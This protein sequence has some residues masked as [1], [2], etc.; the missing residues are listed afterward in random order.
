MSSSIWIGLAALGAGFVAAY[1]TLR[2]SM[3]RTRLQ[4]QAEA[5]SVLDLARRKAE[6]E[7]LEAR[8]KVE[9][10][11]EGLRS[12]FERAE[13]RSELEIENKLKEIRS[14]EESIG[15]LDHQLEL[16]Q[17]QIEKEL[18]ELK[19]NRDSLSQMSANMQRTM[20]NLASM[21]VSEI[22]ESLREQVRLD[23][24]DE[25]KKLRKEVLERSEAEIHREARR[26]L[27]AAMQRIASKPNN[28][29]TAAI[30]QLPNDEMK[31]RIIG[32]EGRNIKCFETA[33]GTTLLIDESP[34]MVMV[35]SFDPVRREIA[36]TALERLVKDGRIH[37]ATIEEF[38]GEARNDVDQIVEN[39]GDAAVE[40]LKISRLHPEIITLLGKLKFRTSYSQNVLEHSVEVGFLASIIASELGLDP[41]IAKRAALL[42][43]IGKAI[44]GEYEGSHA[45]VGAEFVKARGEDDIVVNAVAAHHEEVPPESLYAAVVILAD[46]I[47]AV[48]PGARAETLTSYIDRL[49]DLEDVALS[50]EGIRSA[51]AIQAGREV[52]VIVDPERTSDEQA[53]T[54]ARDI[55]DKIEQTLEFPSSIRVTVVREQRYIETAK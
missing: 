48:R 11:I 7:T 47:S 50:F 36:K 46:T 25:L 8:A 32:R 22:K 51:Y 33:T 41:N 21:D 38:V 10:E 53:Q 30:V 16:R 55:R 45:I 27:L 29:I 26:T 14:H 24:R 35:S 28:D 9:R 13:Q 12:D 17:R 37:P 44:D 1:F 54:L 23:C 52:R 42:H 20:A 19:Q 6:I 40:H 2:W 39:A 5:E 43:D 18:E 3:R 49:R 15:L 31:G 4:A 34:S